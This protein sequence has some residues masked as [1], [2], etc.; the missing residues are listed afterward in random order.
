MHATKAQACKSSLA[1][2]A[3]VSQPSMARLPF[4]SRKPASHSH[5]WSSTWVRVLQSAGA[6]TLRWAAVCVNCE[7][8][9]GQTGNAPAQSNLSH[10]H[11]RQNPHWCHESR[12]GMHTFRCRRLALCNLR[13]CPT[14]NRRSVCKYR[15]DHAPNRHESLRVSHPSLARSLLVSRKPAL[16]AHVWLSTLG[17][18]LQSVASTQKRER[19][20]VE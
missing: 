2:S 6:Q 20:L 18:V 17:S 5:V 4:E 10:N 1:E 16:H 14:A 19:A 7:R 13:V 12:C 3:P 9:T 15:V 8:K 11:R